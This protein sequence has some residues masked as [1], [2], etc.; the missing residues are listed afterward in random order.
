MKHV[1][2]VKFGPFLND[3]R[4]RGLDWAWFIKLTLEKQLKLGP[5]MTIGPLLMHIPS[6]HTPVTLMH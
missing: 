6:H 2:N 5:L 1:M 4:G 3:E